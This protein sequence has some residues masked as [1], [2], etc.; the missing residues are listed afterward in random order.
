MSSTSFC[1]GRHRDL[2]LGREAEAAL[3][4]NLRVGVADGLVDGLGHHR[5]AIHLLEV[6]HRHL[7]GAEA[8]ESDLVLEVNQL[9][10]RLGIEIRC[11]NADLEFVLQ[12]LG[13]GF[14][15]LHGVN[16]LPLASGL[17][18]ADIVNL[19]GAWPRKPAP[20]VRRT[21][22]LQAFTPWKQVLQ[23]SSA[24][25]VE[26]LVRAEGLEPPQLSSLEPK[27]SASTSSA[28]PADSISSG[29]DAAGGGLI[30]WATGSQQKNG[31]F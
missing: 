3:G 27:S 18:G 22:F 23:H 12:S 19:V 5:A 29:R 6:A 17:D 26:R 21:H 15:D 4:E 7:A 28:T 31:R 30:T 1:L 16:L 25:A 2:G 10:A 20:V 11:G 24:N 9:G 8:V 13:E 14:G